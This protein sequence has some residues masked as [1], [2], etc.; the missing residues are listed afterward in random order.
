MASVL[1]VLFCHLAACLSPV[2]I[3][4]H[5]LVCC[6]IFM[7]RIIVTALLHFPFFSHCRLFTFAD[8]AEPGPSVVAVVQV[9]TDST[10]ALLLVFL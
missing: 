7:Y 6:K 10:F 4:Q 8:A 3:T 1:L 9:S 2:N 5:Y